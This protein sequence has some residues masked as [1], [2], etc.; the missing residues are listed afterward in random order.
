MRATWTPPRAP[1]AQHPGGYASLLMALEE[2]I[3]PPRLVVLRGPQAQMR[4]WRQVLDQTYLP[5]T[6]ILGLAPAV[7]KLP[8]PLAKPVTQTTVNAWVCAGVTCLA[9]V[10]KLDQLLGIFKT[11]DFR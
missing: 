6:L 10:D 4:S 2:A 5:T 7:A 9:P 11:D 8:A 3:E 1:L